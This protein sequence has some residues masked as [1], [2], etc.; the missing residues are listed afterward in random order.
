LADACQTDESARE[1]PTVESQAASHRTQTHTARHHAE[2][3][4]AFV[5]LSCSIGSALWY[6][7]GTK[8]T[9]ENSA[10]RRVMA[11]PLLFDI[12]L[13]RSSPEALLVQ[14][15]GLR[16]KIRVS[17]KEKKSSVARRA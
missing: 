11:A 12:S 15:I 8:Y 3:S 16:E 9:D 17:I 13:R 7:D 6:G 5:P 1:I 10:K 14:R 4:E 2:R